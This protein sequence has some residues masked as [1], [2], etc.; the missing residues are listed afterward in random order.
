[1]MT[2]QN[3]EVNI[4][5]NVPLLVRPNTVLF[6]LNVPGFE[7]RLLTGD[8]RPFQSHYG[9]HVDVYVRNSLMT[10]NKFV[11]LLF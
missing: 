9:V 10:F 7:P 2:S 1:M 3:A 4:F 5:Q 8:A 11:T 6:Y